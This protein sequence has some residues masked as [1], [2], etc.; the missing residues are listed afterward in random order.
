MR[1][2]LS[3]ETVVPKVIGNVEPR[4]E[5]LRPE[6]ALEAFFGPV[7]VAYVSAESFSDNMERR[8]QHLKIVFWPAQAWYGCVH[9]TCPFP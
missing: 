3:G 9:C 4:E 2:D 7:S 1:V 8:G 6:I 5:R